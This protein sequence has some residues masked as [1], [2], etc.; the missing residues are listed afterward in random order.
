[1]PV[2]ARCYISRYAAAGSSQN[3]E[4]GHTCGICAGSQS[5]QA[6]VCQVHSLAAVVL[7]FMDAA[8]CL[9]CQMVDQSC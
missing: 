7:D 4:F 3:A 5:L 9:A 1:M 2:V 6:V 8:S